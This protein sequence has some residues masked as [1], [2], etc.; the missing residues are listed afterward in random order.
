MHSGRNDFFK[1]DQPA[2]NNDV[3]IHHFGHN[4]FFEDTGMYS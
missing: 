3:N 1:V 4:D 2:D